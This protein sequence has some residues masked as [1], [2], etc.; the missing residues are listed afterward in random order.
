MSGFI[1]AIEIEK[2]TVYWSFDIGSDIE[3]IE[4]HPGCNVLFSGTSDGYLYMFKLS[5]NEIKTM[6]NG[7]SQS[8]V[9]CFKVLPDGKRAVS[10]Y[11][12]GQVII[13]DL[14][15]Q[16]MLFNVKSSKESSGEILC[17]DISADGNLLA[18]GGV[19]LKLS[20]LNLNNGKIIETYDCDYGE[21]KK[22]SENSGEEEEGVKGGDENSIE[23]VG[24]CK[25]LP[26]LA[27]VTVK[28]EILIW[29][30]N[31]S[32]LRHKSVNE[33]K[34]GFSKLIWNMDYKL[35]I[36]ALNGQIFEFYGRNLELKAKYERHEAEILD[37]CLSKD[38]KYLFTASD[39]HKVKVFQ[40]N[41]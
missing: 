6:C 19:D 38:F 27:C 33:Y 23:S 16:Q 15:T 2:K 14:K 25:V 22:K 35:F 20:I 24:F 36:S 10:T 11:S 1:S 30:I 29:D 28:G 32:T 18:Y 21:K 41:Q 9:T 39:D 17:I 37:F 8:K 5:T 13:W 40:L 34:F 31:N 26:L 12:T 7:D 3:L 4:W